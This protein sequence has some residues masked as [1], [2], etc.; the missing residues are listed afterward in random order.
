MKCGLTHK[1]G[2]VV[3]RKILYGL[4]VVLVCASVAFG[5]GSPAHVVIRNAMKCTGGNDEVF[6]QE[7]DYSDWE[8]DPADD[9]DQFSGVTVLADEWSNLPAPK[10]TIPSRRYALLN[11]YNPVEIIAYGDTLEISDW[12]GDGVYSFRVFD[13]EGRFI[14]GDSMLNEQHTSTKI[15]LTPEMQNYYLEFAQAR[16]NYGS[17]DANDD[18][19]EPEAPS[20]DPK[21]S[22]EYCYILLRMSAGRT[23]KLKPEDIRVP[24]EI[25]GDYEASQAEVQEYMLRRNIKS[26]GDLTADDFVNIAVERA[27]RLSRSQDVY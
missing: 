21:T 10:N 18:D 3:M 4:A 15:T 1:G 17:D 6:V 2:L 24:P 5:E 22:P 9:P 12:G 20:L 23:R 14:T 8:Y 11:P 25:A 26:I 13:S 7:H 27:R 19:A 16:V